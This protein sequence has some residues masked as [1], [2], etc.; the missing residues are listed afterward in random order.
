MGIG[1]GTIKKV[2]SSIFSGGKA[3]K[4][5]G[6]AFAV[7]TAMNLQGGEAKLLNPYATRRY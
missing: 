1:V 6:G 5:G 4:L 3:T 7:D 2:G